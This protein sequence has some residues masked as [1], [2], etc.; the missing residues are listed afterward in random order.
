[1]RISRRH[2]NPEDRAVPDQL[3]E[4]WR[5]RRD[6]AGVDALDGIP[7]LR[8]RDHMVRRD[9][10]ER[11]QYE[12]ALEQ[13]RMGKAQAGLVDDDVVVGQDVDIDRPWSPAHVLA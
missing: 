5:Q 8:A 10:V 2:P 6:A 4:P 1:M 7:D 12:G 13:V 11:Y 3:A 9:L